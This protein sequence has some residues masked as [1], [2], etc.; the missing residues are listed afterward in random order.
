MAF[1][2]FTERLAASVELLLSAEDAVAVVVDHWGFPRASPGEAPSRGLAFDEAAFARLLALGPRYPDLYVKASAFFRVSSE[3]A[4]HADLRGRFDAL[5]GAYGADRLL[6]GSDFP[7]V[8]L[9]P[10][11]QAG[12]LD[13]AR[14]LAYN[15]PEASR[16]AILGGTAARLFKFPAP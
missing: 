1:G 14:R 6:W 3:D 2:G 11:G 15:L 10:G 13:A 7:F 9:Q 5:V 12:S 8:A 4:P 16:T